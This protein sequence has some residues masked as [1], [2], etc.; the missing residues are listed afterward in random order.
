MSTPVRIA[1]LVLGVVGGLLSV[2]IDVLFIAG[3]VDDVPENLGRILVFGILLVVYGAGLAGGVLAL[4]K[5]GMAA[6]L[7]LIA[8]VVEFFSA[9]LF[10]FFA[11][12]LLFACLLHIFGAILAF[13]GWRERPQTVG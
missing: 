8:A 3:T 13:V 2:S 5:P 6:I 7:Q 12:I 11:P 10:L 9:P 1:A 4:R